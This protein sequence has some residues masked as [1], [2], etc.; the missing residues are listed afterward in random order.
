[1][2]LIVAPAVITVLVEAMAVLIEII[3]CIAALLLMSVAVGHL[4]V[5]AY[6]TQRQFTAWFFVAVVTFFAAAAIMLRGL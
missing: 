2:V 6:K 5:P 3:L 4:V 1:M